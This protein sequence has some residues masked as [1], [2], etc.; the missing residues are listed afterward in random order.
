MYLWLHLL[1]KPRVS[2]CMIDL[3]T[4]HKWYIDSFLKFKLYSI[5]SKL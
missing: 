2:F 4:I 5:L 3:E 1:S